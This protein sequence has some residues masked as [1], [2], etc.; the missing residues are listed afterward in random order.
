MGDA[1]IEIAS[2]RGRE[3]PAAPLQ[4]LFKSDEDMKPVIVLLLVLM[5]AGC[6]TVPVQ[7][8]PGNAESELSLLRKQIEDIHGSR[9]AAAFASLH[10][11]ATIFEWRGRP[12][13]VTGRTALE[14]SQREMWAG[15]RE[16]RL[17]L[18]VS[19]L[20][21]HGDRAYEYGSYEE[22]WID[23]YGSK[24]TE[25]GRYV[26]AYAR[27]ADG[28]WRIARTFGFADLTATKRLTE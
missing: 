19:E 7:K 24:L 18:Q 8:S 26:T 12:S 16:L 21:I 6:S 17:M 3:I 14:K 15:R 4:W 23:P 11:D 20:R 13:A 1:K 10:T 5:L 28:Q 27:E 2:L 22:T 25:F 9:D